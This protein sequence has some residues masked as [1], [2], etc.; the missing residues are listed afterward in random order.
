MRLPEASDCEAAGHSI[1]LKDE[2]IMELGKLDKGVAAVFQNDWLET[3]LT[4]I[5]KCSDK[6][7]VSGVK[8]NDIQAEKDFLGE[9]LEELVRQAEDNTCNL[10][11]LKDIVKKAKI[12]NSKK[13]MLEK[14][15][16]EYH[17]VYTTAITVENKREAYNELIAKLLNCADLIRMYETDLPAGILKKSQMTDEIQKAGTNWIKRISAGLESYA[18]FWDRHIK[19]QVLFSVILNEM[20]NSKRLNQYKVVLYCAKHYKC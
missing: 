10:P 1:G 8:K 14:M 7:E 4:K 11:W 16:D 13:H 17:T 15:I 5:D 19:N 20:K 12:D 3:V 9:L 18:T 2:Q 6:Y